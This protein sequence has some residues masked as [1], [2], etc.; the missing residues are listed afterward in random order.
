MCVF[1]LNDLLDLLVFQNLLQTHVYTLSNQQIYFS[2]SLKGSYW[3]Q[4]Y[5]ILRKIHSNN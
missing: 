4:I 2:S 3:K 5:Y 1:E